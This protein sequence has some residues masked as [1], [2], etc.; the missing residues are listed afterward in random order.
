MRS[1]DVCIHVEKTSTEMKKSRA[2]KLLSR[3]YN[4]SNQCCKPEESLTI[5]ESVSH[6]ETTMLSVAAEA[7]ANATNTIKDKNSMD[8]CEKRP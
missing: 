1:L 7:A 3:A 4:A 8:N 6:T 2:A 5:T